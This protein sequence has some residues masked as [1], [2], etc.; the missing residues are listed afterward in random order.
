M[1]HGLLDRLVRGARRLLGG[2]AERPAEPAAAAAEP[3]SPGRPTIDDLLPQDPTARDALVHDF[4]LERGV[5]PLEAPLEAEPWRSSALEDRVSRAR[6]AREAG[7]RVTLLVYERECGDAASFRYFGYNVAQ[8]LSSSATWFG[9]FLFLEELEEAPELAEELAGLASAA[10]LVRCRIRPDLRTLCGRLKG[11]GAR[12]AYLIDDLALGANA[13]PHII[14]VMANDPADPFE[15]DFWTGTTVRFQL[16]SMMADLL[17]VPGGFFAGLLGEGDGQGLPVRVLHSSLNDEQVGVAKQVCSARGGHGGNRD[18]G[19]S[20]GF[21]VGYF[22]GTSSHQED[23]ALVRDPL[24]SLL[25]SRADARLLLGGR[26]EIDEELQQ[27]WREGRVI[28]MPQVDYATLQ[29]L[30]AAVDVVLAPLVVDDFA[31]CK[32]ALKV[33]EAGVVDTCAL[34]SP[35]FAYEEAIENGVTGFVCRGP[36]DWG[37]A[38]RRLCDN[39][40]LCRAMG[41]AARSRALERS[42]GNAVRAEAE[43]VLDDLLACPARPVPPAVDRALDSVEVSDWGNP[44]EASPAFAR[45]ARW[46]EVQ[47]PMP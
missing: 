1:S 29:C 13:A 39:P 22:S 19:R 30:Q 23:F 17:I 6:A 42:W 4:L 35:S 11:D 27:L 16:A 14:D 5:A 15:R 20:T 38:L 37:R 31:N 41:A 28:L 33:F 32:S 36:E 25:R 24:V 7:R 9:A 46:P 43:G 18:R 45:L 21:V 44:F 3:A 40:G 34:A 12:V 47:G 8:R 2:R 10:V 26:L